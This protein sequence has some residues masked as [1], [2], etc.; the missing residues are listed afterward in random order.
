MSWMTGVEKY[1]L[2]AFCAGVANYALRNPQAREITGSAGYWIVQGMYI[3][4]ISMKHL[5]NGQLKKGLCELALG[6]LF[7]ANGV[8]KLASL[9]EDA[10]TM[11][12]RMWPYTPDGQEVY[13][14]GCNALECTPPF[15]IKLKCH[16]DQKCDFSTLGSLNVG[17]HLQCAMLKEPLGPKGFNTVFEMQKA[18]LR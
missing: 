15:T 1:G 14:Q 2:S 8:F 6:T 4:Y 17:G 3:D 7:V 10:N 18:A 9:V 16:P 5:Y 11:H 12:C 13:M